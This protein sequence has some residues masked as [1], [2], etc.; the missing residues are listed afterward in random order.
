M[1]RYSP[2]HSVLYRYRGEGLAMPVCL[3]RSL[4]SLAATLLFTGLANAQPPAVMPQAVMPPAVE[5]PPRI[6]DM[7]P[8]ELAN[9][10]ATV[11]E[12]GPARGCSPPAFLA[13]VEYL[14]IRPYRRPSDFAILDPLNNLTPEGDI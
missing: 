14:L 6:V 13:S 10:P 5:P 4:V 8:P 3:R 2:P 12:A 1:T 9:R 11:M 7:T